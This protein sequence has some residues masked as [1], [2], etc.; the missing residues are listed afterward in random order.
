MVCD[1]GL[2]IDEGLTPGPRVMAA[3]RALTITGGHG[4]NLGLAREVDSPEDVRRAV[5]EEI[6]AG[7]RVIK[8]IATGGVLTPGIDATFTAFTPDELSAAVDEA[9]KWGRGVAAHAIGA[10]GHHERGR[11]RRGFGRAL[12]PDDARDRAGDEG[13]RHVPI[14]DDL[15]APRDRWATRTSCPST[16]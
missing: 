8:V 16:R 12:L 9:H 1:V 11:R 7:A 14:V 5:R 10:R 4:H 13:A 6:K 2:A 15:R 3:G